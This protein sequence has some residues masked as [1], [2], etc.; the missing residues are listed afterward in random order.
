VSR[1][2][3]RIDLMCSSVAAVDVRGALGLAEEVEEE[4]ATGGAAGSA[5]DSNPCARSR[6]RRNE[7]VMDWSSFCESR[8]ESAIGWLRRCLIEPRGLVV[9]MA[10]S[11]AEGVGSVG[12]SRQ[13]L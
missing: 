10:S 3:A 12:W 5:S 7:D 9:N 8:G 4:G 6:V 2:F 1:G 13:R 11:E